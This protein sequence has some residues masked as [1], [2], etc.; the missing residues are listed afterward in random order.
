MR[1]DDKQSRI[2]SGRRKFIKYGGTGSVV[3]ISG[4]SGCLDTLGS[5]SDGEYPSQQMRYIV[6]FSEGGGT[7][8]FARQIIPQMSE[9]LEV[10]IQIDNIPGAGSLRGAGEMVRAEPDGYTFGGFNPA[11][12]PVSYMMN[13]QDWDMKSLKGVATYARLPFHIYTSS[14]VNI[15]SFDQ[16][17]EK[18]RSGEFTTVG[19]QQRGG[20]THVMATIMK[21]SDEYDWQWEEYVG[22]DGA[23]PAVQAAASNEVPVSFSTDAAGLSAADSDRVNPLISLSSQGSGVFPDDPNVVDAGY[24]SVDYVGE[25]SMCMWMPPETSDERIQTVADSVETAV[26]SDEVQ[27]WADETGNELQYGGPEEADQILND[28]FEKVHENVDVER[29]R[30]NVN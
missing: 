2:D 26:N 14:E 6:P 28:S 27:E 22:Y 9:E 16:L 24:P 1:Q 21:N 15:D 13:P 5:S 29:I 3:A 10:S 25:L 4:L 18:Y 12:T 23:G 8:T 11:S 20:V 19:G 7:D 30:N 17:L